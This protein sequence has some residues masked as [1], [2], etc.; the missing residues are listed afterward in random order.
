MNIEN[1]LNI[2]FNTCLSLP[3]TAIWVLSDL[4]QSISFSQ[5]EKLG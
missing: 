2:H 5:I 1:R 4:G 3:T